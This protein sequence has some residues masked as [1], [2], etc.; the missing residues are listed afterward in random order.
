[1]S[2]AIVAKGERRLPGSKFLVRNLFGNY[3]VGGK[4]LGG[5]LAR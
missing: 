2:V 4:C 3:L 1:M 5:F